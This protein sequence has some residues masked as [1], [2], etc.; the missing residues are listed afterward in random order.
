MSGGGT[1]SLFVLQHPTKQDEVAWV[2][3]VDL[4]VDSDNSGDIDENDDP[5]EEDAPGKRIFIN[6]NADNKNEIVD[7]TDIRQTYLD[8]NLVDKD[9]AEIRLAFDAEAANL[10]GFEL[11]YRNWGGVTMAIP[12]VHP[13]RAQRFFARFQPSRDKNQRVT[14]MR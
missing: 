14:S 8:K 11:W 5:I 7:K 13:G 6:T 3:A 10:M 12:P 2:P 4:D 1:V 9:F